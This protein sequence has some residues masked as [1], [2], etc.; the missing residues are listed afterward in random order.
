MKSISER[1]AHEKAKAER[2]EGWVRLF[3][4]KLLPAVI[5]VRGAPAKH[6]NWVAF[7]RKAV[8]EQ[9]RQTGKPPLC[10]NTNCPNEITATP[11]AFVLMRTAEDD[12]V[13]CTAMSVC[14]ECAKKS[15]AEILAV[16]REQMHHRGLDGLRPN[17]PTL[18]L[19]NV[20][21]QVIRNLP[22]GIEIATLVDNE[23]EPVSSLAYAIAQWLERGELPRLLAMWHG[24]HNCH[25]IV[26]TMME[27][28]R[29]IGF[30]EFFEAK[31]GFC[32][33]RLSNGEPMGEHSWIECNGWAI[34]PSGGAAGSPIKIVRLDRYYNLMQIAKGM[35]EPVTGPS[36]Q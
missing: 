17:P 22:G 26:D 34:D 30:D 20:S 14:P 1:R 9:V 18:V 10:F 36:N 28:F 3:D 29:R 6:S 8:F 23:D 12:A 24:A 19:D 13:P 35:A 21:C 31:C 33:V 5:L 16:L 25:A 2:C 11:P 27:D 7:H 32:G 4:E 15:E